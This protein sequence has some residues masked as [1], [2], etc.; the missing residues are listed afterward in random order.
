MI[1]KRL[2]IIVCCLYGLGACTNHSSEDSKNHN[3][4]TF[5]IKM[6]NGNRSEARQKHEMAVFREV[7]KNTSA[8][9]GPYKIIEDT[10]EYRGKEEAFVFSKYN[11][12]VFVTI[13]GNQKFDKDDK[14]SVNIPISKG[15]LG[16]RI[17]IVRQTDADLFAEADSAKIKQLKNGVPISWS[18]A[19]IFRENGY[20]VV[21][22]GNFGDILK[23]LEN[24]EF[25]YTAFGANEVINIYETKAPEGLFIDNHVIFHYPFPLVFYINP[26][27]EKL[28]E[29]IKIGLKN[30][31]KNGTLD[32]LFNAHYGEL[33]ER[34]NLRQRKILKLHNP[35]VPPEFDSTED[36]L[37]P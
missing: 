26:N 17:A 21:E 30:I 18:D 34:L 14:I 12:D 4:D 23:R 10:S 16:Y 19:V 1:L 2:G 36:F 33:T 29:R 31:K 3:N 28:A 20:R 22:N 5:N 35:M 25:D 9:Y 6:W 32:S 27:K 24:N 15:I 7:L 13:A 8:E 11:H 37:V